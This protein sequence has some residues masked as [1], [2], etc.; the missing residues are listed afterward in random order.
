[1]S[2][3]LLGERSRRWTRHNPPLGSERSSLSRRAISDGGSR[4]RVLLATSRLSC[5]PRPPHAPRGVLFYWKGFS[6]AAPP[7]LLLSH[8][9]RMLRYPKLVHQLNIHSY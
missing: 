6:S 3:Y 9:L 8:A 7:L 4:F 2:R 5:R 1:M